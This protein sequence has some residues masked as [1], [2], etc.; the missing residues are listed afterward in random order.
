M[1]AARMPTARELRAV[2]ADIANALQGAAGLVALLRWNTQNCADDAVALE[3]AIG[4]TVS[5][6]K[7]L[8]PPPIRRRTR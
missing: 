2:L 7:R 3:A 8:Q 6:L 1:T 4:R 5:A